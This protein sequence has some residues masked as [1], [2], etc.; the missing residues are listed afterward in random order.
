LSVDGAQATSSSVGDPMVTVTGAGIDGAN[1]SAL[2]PVTASESSN[3]V[4]PSELIAVMV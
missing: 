3:V 1:P 4:L 2:G